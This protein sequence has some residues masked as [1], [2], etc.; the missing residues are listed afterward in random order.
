MV[1][2]WDEPTKL[3]PSEFDDDDLG[4]AGDLGISKGRQPTAG[5]EA[6]LLR[7]DARAAMER[8]Y[9]PPDAPA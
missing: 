6:A 4:W 2:P 1:G 5:E 3:G 9:P 7:Q 8:A